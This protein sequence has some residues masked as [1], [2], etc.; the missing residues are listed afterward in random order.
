[1]EGCQAEVTRIPLNYRRSRTFTI[2]GTTQLYP[3]GID[4]F[5][6]NI[7]L[8]R[9][10][11]FVWFYTGNTIKYFTINNGLF[12]VFQTVGRDPLMC[13]V[14]IFVGLRY[15]FLVIQITRDL[16]FF[17]Q[18]YIIDTPS[19]YVQNIINPDNCRRILKT[20]MLY[21]NF[22]VIITTGSVDTSLSEEFDSVQSKNITIK[23]PFKYQ[24]LFQ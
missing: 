24:S 13:H 1:M 3:N 2:L 4:S 7:N 5:K 16:Y 8:R 11:N 15:I 9:I 20:I 6:S 17:F 10:Y 22:V 14:S 19:I 18:F 23:S 12:S 21:N